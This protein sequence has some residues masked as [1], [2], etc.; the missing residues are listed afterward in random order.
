MENA[1]A[2]ANY[3][4][5]KGLQENRPITPMKAIKLVYI[6]HGYHLALTN[7]TPLI[8]ES[9]QAWKFGPVVDSVYKAFRGYGREGITSLY[10]VAGPN[11]PEIPY[12]TDPVKIA[13]LDKIWN[14]YKGYDGLQ[15]SALTHQQHTPW[16][17]AWN[18]MKGQNFHAFEIPNQLIMQHYQKLVQ[19]AA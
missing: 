1:L 10:S 17:I 3:F 5:Y 4:V 12:I 14:L 2:V 16:D 13:F 9:I 11:G 8:D 15:L 18:S 7:G 6:S 19:P